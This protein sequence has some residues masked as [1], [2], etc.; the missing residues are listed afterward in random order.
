MIQISPI[1]AAQHYATSAQFWEGQAKALRH[2]LDE[3]TARIADLERSSAQQA[4]DIAYA[5]SKNGQA[6]DRCSPGD[7]ATV[8][9]P[10][11]APRT[12]S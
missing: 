6:F 3:A 4:E 7:A 9:L 1:S 12:P 8:D 5:L 11:P 10:E 2:E